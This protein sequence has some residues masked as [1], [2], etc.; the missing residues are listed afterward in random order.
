V[1]QNRV[2]IAVQSRDHGL[3]RGAFEGA[4]GI[5]PR[6]LHRQGVN[7]GR[8]FEIT[9]LDEP[10]RRALMAD[11]N[12]FGDPHLADGA[13]FGAEPAATAN[14][15][16]QDFALDRGALAVIEERANIRRGGE[17]RNFAFLRRHR[18]GG[19][20]MEDKPVMRMWT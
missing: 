16:G 18:S 5:I 20:R 11:W 4:G 14:V 19:L 7:L 8:A 17:H 6:D 15:T 2:A 13:R 12:L 3:R 1:V 10:D 9:D